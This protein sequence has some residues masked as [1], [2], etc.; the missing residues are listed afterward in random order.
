M[1]ISPH[2]FRRCS[3]FLCRRI[4]F[5]V[6]AYPERRTCVCRTVYVRTP[7]GVR[8]HQH[9]I[10]MPFGVYAALP[11]EESEREN[12]P[13][14]KKNEK[15]RPLHLRFLSI[16]A[17]HYT[18]INQMLMIMKKI[19]TIAFFAGMTLFANAQAKWINNVKLSGYGIM[20]YQ[21][22]G[23]KGSESNS[24]GLRLARIS[25]D[26]RVL[27]DWYWRMQLQ[28]NG[29]TSTLGSSPRLVDLFVEWQK[30]GFFKVKFGQFKNPFTFENPLH[31]ID[32]G[33]MSYGQ[34]VLKLAGFSDRTGMHSSN[35][36]DIGILFQGD[37]LKN[38]NGRNLLH[39]QVGVFNGQGIN[40][41]D[42][43]QQKDIIGGAWV[44]PVP[45]I[46]IGAFGWVGSYARKGFW[47]DGTAPNPNDGINTSKVRKLQQRRYAFSAEYMVNDW[48]FRSEYIHSTGNAFSTTLVNTND[49]TA[50]N[51]NLSANG[52]KAQG[53]YAL[54]IAPI[55]KTFHAK[56]RYDMYQADGTTNTMK[57]M[58]EVGLDYEFTKNIQL[59]GE[60]AFVNDRTL[61]DRNYSMIDFEVSFRF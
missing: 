20:Q 3:L 45:G 47:T 14:A 51:C 53:V 42:I 9:D 22:S 39:Y 58:Y 25:L 24:F 60:Y 11:R 5:G 32:Q 46:R 61:T 17:L 18:T 19:I 27:S 56:A 21:Y 7:N 35:G 40:V 4:S 12:A 59:S 29:N 31:P 15:K 36:R 26:G 13:D 8:R 44:M 55:R 38:V 41:K 54:V 6:R 1:V 28:V 48:T 33:F 57:T 49:A 34:N 43:D 10:G 23:Q 16:F 2:A 30:F 50:T 52:N 37:F